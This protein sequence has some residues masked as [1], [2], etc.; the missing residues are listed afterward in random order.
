MKRVTTWTILLVGS[1][2]LLGCHAVAPRSQTPQTVCSVY[3]SPRGGCTEHVVTVLRGAQR[4]VL[5]QAYS[6]TSG[7]IAQ[8]LVEA[9]QRGVR[10][11]VILDKSQQTDLRSVAL[12]LARAGVPVR[13]DSVHAIAHNKVMVI[14]DQT[15]LTGSFNFTQGAE[16]RNAENLLIVRDPTL[17]AQYHDNWQQ[18]RAHSTTYSIGIAGAR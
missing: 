15:V 17:A 10:V 14:D 3:F 2:G 7:P 12:F 1:L 8:A 16:E 11:E 4:S 5:V 13:I 9:H 6:F 18:H